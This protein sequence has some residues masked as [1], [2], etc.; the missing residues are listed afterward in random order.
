MYQRTLGGKC[1]ASRSCRLRISRRS[2]RR[3]QRCRPS[4][5][6]Q[7][8]CIQGPT[9]LCKL[10]P[11]TGHRGRPHDNVLCSLL[12]RRTR[13]NMH[14]GWRGLKE[15]LVGGSAKD[16]EGCGVS[17]GRFALGAVNRPGTGARSGSVTDDHFASA[18]D[19]LDLNSYTRRRPRS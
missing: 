15:R 9:R 6:M 10:R 5:S 13:D 1:S 14:G 12:R 4:T 16:E 19:P 7:L 2:L 3:R 8:P 17:S 18:P 11:R